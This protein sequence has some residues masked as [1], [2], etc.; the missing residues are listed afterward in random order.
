MQATIRWIDNVAFEATSGSAHR[1]VLDGAPEHG[2]QNLGIRPM[3]AMLIGLG[4]CSAFDVVTMLRKGRQEITGCVV[5]LSAE[6]ADTIPSVFTNVT[7]KYVITGRG[8]STAR[9]TRAV[10]LSAEKY[11]SASA[12]FRDAGVRLTHTFEVLESGDDPSPR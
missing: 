2:G 4:G 1:I 11:C 3:E 10:E 12:M 7:M 8:V 5:E 6:R 9:V